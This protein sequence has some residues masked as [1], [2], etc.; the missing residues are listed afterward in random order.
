MQP[1]RVL[2]VRISENLREQLTAHYLGAGRHRKLPPVVKGAP[3]IGGE[4]VSRE[5]SRRRRREAAEVVEA[6]DNVTTCGVNGNREL[7]LRAIPRA[8]TQSCRT[9]RLVHAHVVA[10]FGGRHIHPYPL[11][12][13]GGET[14]HGRHQLCS[15]NLCGDLGYERPERRDD[16]DPRDGVTRAAQRCLHGSLLSVD[17]VRLPIVS[18]GG[19]RDLSPRSHSCQVETAHR[20]FLLRG[21]VPNGSDF[22]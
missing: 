5:G 18:G 22:K 4:H 11:D 16:E 9:P 19:S 10:A 15:F 8:F 17:V 2:D 3:A 1:P 14:A 7:R 12:G 21:G 20:S 13:F 6:N